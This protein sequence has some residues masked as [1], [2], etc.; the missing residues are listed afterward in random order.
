MVNG[1]IHRVFDQLTIDQSITAENRWLV[2]GQTYRVFDQLTIDHVGNIPMRG[3]RTTQ[4]KIEAANNN[5]LD[6]LLFGLR[7]GL[8]LLDKR[9]AALDEV[10][11]ILTLEHTIREQ[12][13]VD[14]L[15]HLA[16]LATNLLEACIALLVKLRYALR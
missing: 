16:V 10:G 13:E 3:V 1:Q 11:E 14:D 12:C 7:A 5:V 6:S 8:G 4:K 2:N 9:Y 15:A